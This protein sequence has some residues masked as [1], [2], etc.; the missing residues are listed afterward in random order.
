M[1]WFRASLCAAAGLAAGAGAQPGDAGGYLSLD[2][3]DDV[4]TAQGD[5]I[6]EQLTIETW[7]YPTKLHP[8]WTA[9]LVAYGSPDASSFDFGIGPPQDPRLRFF[10]NWNQGQKTIIG[11]QP[12][13]MEQW[14]HVAVTYD[15]EVARLYINGELDAEKTF[16]TPILPS[17]DGALLAV[18]DDYPG[19]SEFL[20]G[21]FDEVR[22]WSVARSQSDIQASMATPLTGT[23]AGLFVYYTFDEIIGQVVL[24]ESRSGLHARLGLSLADESNDPVRHRYAPTRL[25]ALR[26]SSSDPALVRPITG[27]I[28]QQLATINAGPPSGGWQELIHRHQDLHQRDSFPCGENLDRPYV[29]STAYLDGHDE[30]TLDNCSSAF[31][32]VEFDMPPLFRRPTVIGT[33]NADDLAVAFMNQ[34]PLSLLVTEQDVTNLGADRVHTRHRLL[35]WPTPDPIFEDEVPNIVRPGRNSLNFGVCSDA[36]EFEPAGL[37]FDVIVQYECL[38]DW[39]VDGAKDTTDFTAFLNDWNAR[40]PESD[41]NA[42]GAINTQDVLAFINVWVF[43]CPE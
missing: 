34:R 6:T 40:E 42:D 20:G 2:G 11:T 9:G 22:L 4:V 32:R 23:E 35:G 37:E 17:G 26:L 1:Q 14:Q 39:N 36:S 30:I 24:D 41:L 15:G 21:S 16:N 7:I 25:R 29:D 8:Q 27:S 33:A 28:D 5:F 43:G 3:V 38:A 12:V 19:A 13:A 18:G 10:I 31:Y